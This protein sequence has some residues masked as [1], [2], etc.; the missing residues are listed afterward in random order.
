M[1]VSIFARLQ[2]I[3]EIGGVRNEANNLTPSGCSKLASAAARLCGWS[4]AALSEVEGGGILPKVPILALEEKSAGA[5]G[6]VMFVG[7]VVAGFGA[8]QVAAGFPNLPR[9]GFRFLKRNVLGLVGGRGV[10]PNQV[11]DMLLA[12][13]G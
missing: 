9:R 12:L 11:W 3:E 10:F 1:L 13:L 6:V 8:G 4:W 5:P 7:L 2:G